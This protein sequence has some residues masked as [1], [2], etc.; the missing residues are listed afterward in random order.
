MEKRSLLFAGGKMAHCLSEIAN[1]TAMKPK[2][3]MPVFVKVSPPR[4]W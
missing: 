2:A 4:A 1:G 3:K